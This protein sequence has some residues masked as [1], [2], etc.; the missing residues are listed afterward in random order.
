MHP[1]PRTQK[2]SVAC[3]RQKRAA[4]NKSYVGV[5]LLGMKTPKSP[6][7]PYTT[8]PYYDRIHGPRPG[9]TPGKKPVPTG[10]SATPARPASVALA[11]VAALGQSSRAPEPATGLGA[12]IL[13]PKFVAVLGALR[14]AQQP[15]QRT[16][17]DVYAK[18]Q[19]VAAEADGQQAPSG[20]LALPLEMRCED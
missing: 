8:F 9:P 13:A 19:K 16:L 4:A 14:G 5:V 2:P 20:R 17:Q 10:S 15:A 3:S 6:R 12:V 1:N 7:A 11:A 18:A